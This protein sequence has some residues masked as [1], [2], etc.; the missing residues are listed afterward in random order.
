M[1]DYVRGS[2]CALSEDDTQ[3]PQRPRWSHGDA[4]TE[5]LFLKRPNA[6]LKFQQIFNLEGAV[7]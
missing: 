2:L 4:H 6:I 1:I 3:S 5:S 7:Y